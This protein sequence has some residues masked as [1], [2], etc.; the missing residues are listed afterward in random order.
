MCLD[1][2]GNIQ[3]QQ[4]VDLLQHVQAGDLF[5]FNNTKVIPARLLGKKETGGSVE[6]LIERIIDTCTAQA[7]VAPANHLNRIQC[8]FDGDFRTNDRSCQ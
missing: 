2:Q 8:F 7:H 6:V 1:K 5:V 3:H 4:F